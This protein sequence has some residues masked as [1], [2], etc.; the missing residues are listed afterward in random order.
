M[1]LLD[2]KNALVAG[3]ANAK[4]IAWGIAQSLHEQ[5]ATVGFTCVESAR[6]RVEKL[7][8]EIGSSVVVS[9]D[10]TNDDEIAS[11]I[12]QVGAGLG[13]R[14]DTLVHSIAYANLDDLGGEFLR[15]S[16]A[17]WRT[18]LE[19]S[20]YSLVAMSRAARKHMTAG[21]SIMTLTFIGGEHVVQSYNMMGVAK[22]ALDCSMRYLAYD[23]GPD[24]IR[25]NAISP[26]P[27]E[28]MSSM[29][30]DRFDVA[31]SD[32]M[33]LSPLLSNISARDVGE[34][35]VYL[36]SDL[37]RKVTGTVVYVDSG[38]HV[39]GAGARP[40]PRATHEDT[41]APSSANQAESS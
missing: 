12:D 16:R 30:I 4:S 35:A 8:R 18:A 31:L 26:G 6:R 17:G 14:L 29:V 1:G 38:L 37:S 40:H 25:V 24:N 34:T 3:V 22:A 13:G 10:V 36:A 9:C 41:A 21:G 15:V 39:V 11:A 28:T 23:L 32:A 5:G 20:A 2:G 33:T 7:A 27:I 19:V